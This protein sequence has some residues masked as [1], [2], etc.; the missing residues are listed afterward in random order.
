MVILFI[1]QTRTWSF[2]KLVL[3]GLA[4]RESLG[5]AMELLPH[6]LKDGGP[7]LLMPKMWTPTHI[8]PSL[9]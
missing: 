3:S 4:Q 8:T 2:R 1:Q 5:L 7:M 6:R 9:L